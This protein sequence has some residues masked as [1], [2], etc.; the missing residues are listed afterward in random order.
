MY[1]NIL[2]WKWRPA[3]INKDTEEYVESLIQ[4]QENWQQTY[5][6]DLILLRNSINTFLSYNSYT[7]INNMCSFFQYKSILN[8][9]HSKNDIAYC[10]VGV[11]ISLSEFSHPSDSP[12]FLLDVSSI[13]ELIQKIRRYKFLLLNIE[14]D[15]NQKNALECICHELI[16]NTLSI[17]ALL[18]LIKHSSINKAYTLAIITDNLKNTSYSEIADTLYSLSSGIK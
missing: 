18:S 2:I 10:I 16:E 8:P 13:D 14:F 5:G 12:L 11:D 3:M 7:A 1:N 6:N 9:F 15:T 4:Q 17:A